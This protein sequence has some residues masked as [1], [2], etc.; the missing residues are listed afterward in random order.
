MNVIRAF[1]FPFFFQVESK[2]FNWITQMPIRTYY[3]L[4]ER[5]ERGARRM[6][7]GDRGARRRERG[8]RKERGPGVE[9]G[10]RWGGGGKRRIKG[11]VFMHY[12]P[13]ECIYGAIAYVRERIS[14]VFLVTVEPLYSGHNWG[15]K[16]CPL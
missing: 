4:G 3:R 2:L 9:G 7:R 11:K 14:E 6:E 5:M 10:V 8:G 13:R 12:T 1:L 16:F 15:M